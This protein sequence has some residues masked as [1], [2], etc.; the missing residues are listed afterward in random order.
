VRLARDASA[1]KVNSGPFLAEP[2][3]GG[4]VNIVVLRDAG[5][6]RGENFPAPGINLD[7]AG[8]LDAG[9]LQAQVKAAD[10]AAH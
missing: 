10:A 4:G 2:P 8:N 5:P 6:V 7:L 9:A 3:V 1:D